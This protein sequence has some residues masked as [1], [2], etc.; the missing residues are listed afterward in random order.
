MT[1]STAENP[2]TK[3]LSPEDLEM[4]KSSE[5]SAGLRLNSSEIKPTI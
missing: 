1:V 2:E 5:D 3:R 4:T